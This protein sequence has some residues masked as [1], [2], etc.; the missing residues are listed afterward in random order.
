MKLCLIATNN[1][2]KLNEARSYNWKQLCSIMSL[3]DIGCNE[4]LPET[5]NTH[6]GKMHCKRR[7]MYMKNTE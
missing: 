2:H 3:N 4:E 6:P 5:G 1:R 7:N